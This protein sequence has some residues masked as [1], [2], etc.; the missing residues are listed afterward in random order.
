[1]RAKLGPEHEALIG[2]VRNVGYKAVR[3]VRGRSA[4]T[5]GDAAERESAGDEAAYGPHAGA[6]SPALPGQ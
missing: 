3:P 2:T 4:T 5:E 6:M 1:L